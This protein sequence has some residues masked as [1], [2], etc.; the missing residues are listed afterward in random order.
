MVEC[1][2]RSGSADHEAGTLKLSATTA[3]SDKLTV[4]STCGLL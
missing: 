4:S 2:D 3:W 1:G